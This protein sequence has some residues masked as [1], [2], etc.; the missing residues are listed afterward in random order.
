MGGEKV[1]SCKTGIRS[2]TEADG[3]AKAA[4]ALHTKQPLSDSLVLG[5]RRRRKMR[6]EDDMLSCIKAG[7][8]QKP[9]KGRYGR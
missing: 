2:Q 1:Q 9:G 7:G 4:P 3:A 8:E 5:W 6:E